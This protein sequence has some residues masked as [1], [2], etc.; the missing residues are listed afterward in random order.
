VGLVGVAALSAPVKDGDAAT[1]PIGIAL[2]VIAQF[3]TG[4]Q[5][6]VEEKLLSGYYLDPIKVVGLE[7]MW[8]FTYYLIFLP[9]AQ[10]IP[11]TDP[12]LCVPP[13]VEDSR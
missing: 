12:N 7:G 9:I 6:V 3:F 2:I 11:C 13:C 1:T 10:V 8:G 5:F 4:I